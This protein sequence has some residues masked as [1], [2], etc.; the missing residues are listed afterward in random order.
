MSEENNNTMKIPVWVIGIFSALIT[1]FA[2]WASSTMLDLRD[3][4]SIL[5]E[6]MRKT[7]ESQND[8]KKFPENISQL[9]IELTALRGE[10]SLLRSEIQKT[11]R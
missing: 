6:K 2:V 1:S 4:T 9:R 7:E 11:K 10:I 8:L 3:R 5:H